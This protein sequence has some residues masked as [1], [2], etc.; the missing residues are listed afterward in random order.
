MTAVPSTRWFVDEA[1]DRL[2]RITLTRQLNAAASGQTEALLIDPMKS[3][4]DADVLERVA[5]AFDPDSLTLARLQTVM[6]RAGVTAALLD[7]LASTNASRVRRS[8]RLA[9]ALCLDAA[10]DRLATLLLSDH[11]TIADVSA[12][13]LGRIRGVRSAEAL[14]RAIQ[15]LGMR[16]RLVAELAR[17]APDLYLEVALGN[18]RRPAV[19]SAAALA[20]GLRRRKAAIRPLG[21]VLAT[22]TRR[23]RVISCHALGWI[24]GDSASALL[25]VALGDREQRVRLAASRALRRGTSRQFAWR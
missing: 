16:R 2:H 4:T 14:L 12:R 24:G 7:G 13:A 21:A 23:Q 11:K 5:S 3:D 1:R 10:V 8:A 22:G 18:R 17:A 6:D 25:T 20:A 9:G 19:V 15:R